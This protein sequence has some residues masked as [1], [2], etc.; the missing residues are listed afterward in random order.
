MISISDKSEPTFVYPVEFIDGVCKG[1]DR[2]EFEKE[3]K[4]LQGNYVFRLSKHSINRSTKQNRVQ[5]W[6]FTEIAKE[7]GHTPSQIKGMCQ[8]KFLL[9]EEVNKLTGEAM[10]YILN[11]S[12]LT[13]IQHNTFM[14]EVRNWAKDYFNINLQIPNEFI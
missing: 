5:W 14:D 2:K 4:G 6:Y 12:E 8:V 7:T 1:F 11:T 9:R 3:T 13:T 10:P